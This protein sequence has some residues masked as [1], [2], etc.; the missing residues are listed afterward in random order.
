MVIKQSMIFFN[1]ILTTWKWEVIFKGASLG[2]NGFWGSE[3][4]L[5][6]V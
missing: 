3:K 4:K 1:K 6:G 5:K 2:D